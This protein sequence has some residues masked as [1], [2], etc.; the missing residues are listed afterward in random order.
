M[1]R[2]VNA[3]H[4]LL[5]LA[6]FLLGA[7]PADAQNLPVKEMTDQAQTLAS[8]DLGVEVP[9][10]P[11][12]AAEPAPDAKA[13]LVVAPIP[14]SNPAFGTGI[15][16]AAV[17][18]Y[19]PNK[20]DQPWVTGLGGGYTSTDSWGAGVFHR[21]S[22]TH[23]RVRF[24][25]FA[26]YGQANLNFYG[27]GP[28]AGSA[29]VSIKLHD[30]AFAGLADAQVRIFDKG[31]LS[32]LYVGARLLYMDLD[33]TIKVPLPGRPDLEPPALERNSAIGM[34]GPSFTFDKRDNAT[35]PRKGVYVTGS[36]LYGASWLGSDFGHHKFELDANAYF[37]LGR[38][39][40][41]GI[42]KQACSVSDDAPYYDLCLFGQHGDLRGYE[43]G[44][45]RDGASWAIQAE[46]RQHLFG[47]LGGV[48]FFGVGGIAEDAGAIWKH[49][50]VLTSGGI[51]I[52]YLA[53]KDANV[54]LRAD[55]AWGKD[56]AAFY[57]GIGEAF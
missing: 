29:G 39:T 23:D 7:A 20:A 31:F 45:Y 24:V 51:G 17:L 2:A 13:D 21:M 28:N 6:G 44:R 54:N 3:S 5:I 42:R 26:G 34:I 11:A 47:K 22:D 32:H 36:L 27:I 12:Q 57:F 30:E 52:R 10:P 25:G 15:A 46:L 55:I 14:I 41:L 18:Y 50:T 1:S 16:G 49:S 4:A 56:G 9:L 40:V 38:T 8:D 35:N 37:P 53:S 19:N 33:S 43:T 48:A